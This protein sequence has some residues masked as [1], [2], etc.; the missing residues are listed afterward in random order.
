MTFI[1][2]RFIDRD[3]ASSF[4]SILISIVSKFHRRGC[5]PGD[6]D[7][8]CLIRE[9]SIKSIL[10]ERFVPPI[11]TNRRRTRMFRLIRSLWSRLS[12]LT[13]STFSSL[14]FLFFFV[15]TYVSIGA[16][17]TFRRVYT[18]V[19]LLT[20]YSTE[21]QTDCSLK[22]QSCAICI[23]LFMN[24]GTFVKSVIENMIKEE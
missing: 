10:C 20:N 4:D 23:L 16:R 19:W 18:R 15:E 24:I 14:S 13:F 8:L 11:N 3:F 2:Y 22:Y 1:I 9:M 21:I 5:L 17:S 7:F 12:S 6:R